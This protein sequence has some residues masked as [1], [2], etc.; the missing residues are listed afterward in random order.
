MEGQIPG[1]KRDSWEGPF[2]SAWISS[3]DTGVGTR[4]LVPENLS[5]LTTLRRLWPGWEDGKTTG[6]SFP[7]V[8]WSFFIFVF[9]GRGPGLSARWV[10]KVGR[11]DG[12]LQVLGDWEGGEPG[13]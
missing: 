5:T 8:S 12:S 10:A 2:Q 6:R 9:L 11:T 4:K 7:L 13:R 3:E 1:R